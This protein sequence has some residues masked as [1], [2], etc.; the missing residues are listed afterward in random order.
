MTIAFAKIL[1]SQ[2]DMG[3]SY[4]VDYNISDLNGFMFTWLYYGYSREYALLIAGLQMLSGILILFKKTERLGIILFLSFMVNILLVNYFYEIDGAKSMSTTLVTMGLFLLFSDWKRLSNYLFTVKQTIINNPFK[5]FK[6]LNKIEWFNLL[7]IP[8][9]IFFGYKG[10][11]DAKKRFLVKN[12]LFGVWRS[13]DNDDS[14]DI[15]KLYFDYDNRF[16]LKDYR[17]NMFYG[18]IEIDSLNQNLKINAEHGSE[19]LRYFLN[20]SLEKIEQLP[21]SDSLSSLKKRIR[22][23]Y[24]LKNNSQ[25]F[26]LQYRFEMKNDTLFLSN[27]SIRLKFL[28]ISKN[29]NL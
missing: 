11:A 9:M 6:L 15:F 7:I 23:Y 12:D 3:I 29:Y 25:P 24:H 22:D 28:N 10:I 1:K 4:N 17:K 18:K 19:E 16:K 26:D 5:N 20:D 14:N 13:I 8:V 21:K 2:F 27:D